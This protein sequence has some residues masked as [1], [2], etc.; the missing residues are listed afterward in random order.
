MSY[1]RVGIYASL[2]SNGANLIRPDGVLDLDHIQKLARWRVR[3]KEGCQSG[4]GPALNTGD[5]YC[6]QG[7]DSSTFLHHKTHVATGAYE[8]PQS[9][10]TR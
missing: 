1:P 4:N 10:R 8:Q 7:F 5:A 9:S 3:N 6:A 2:R